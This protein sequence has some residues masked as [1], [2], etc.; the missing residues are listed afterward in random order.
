MRYLILGAEGQL[1]RAFRE[2]LAAQGHEVTA[3]GRAGADVTDFQA[4]R[5][6]FANLRPQVVV[7][8]AAYNLVDRAEEEWQQAFLVNGIAVKNLAVL[9][10][11]RG[12]VLVHYST[13]YVFDGQKGAP[14]T[15]ADRPRPLCRYGESKLLG[16]ELLLAFGERF[17][18][19]RTSWVFGPGRDNFVTKVLQWAR[20][21]EELRVVTDQ[22]SSPT[23]TRDLA[24]AT[25]ALLE[26]GQYGLYHLT[27][28]GHCSRYEWARFILDRIGWRGKL[29]PAR[30]ADFNL[31]AKRPPFSALDNFPVPHLLGREM[32]PWQE[33]TARFLNELG[34][35]P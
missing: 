22:V 24:A 28:A 7:N 15:I 12:A 10:R 16:E 5:A 25:L 3:L 19:I 26:T 30:D 35:I 14:Y 34:V 9:C 33:A 23:Y 6:V 29:V 1:G 2:L 27:N 32:P 21:R 4:L 20:E 18:L 8:C 11:E 13:D 17:Y 31:P